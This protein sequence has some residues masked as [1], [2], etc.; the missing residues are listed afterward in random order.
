[1]ATR[2]TEKQEAAACHV[3]ELVYSGRLTKAAGVAKLSAEDRMNESTAAIFIAIYKSLRE[4][5]EFR[6]TTSAAAMRVL[7]RSIE[8]G[9]GPAARDRAVTALR[10]HIKYFEQQYDT[11]MASMRVVLAE[12]ESSRDL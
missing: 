8:S 1:M 9:H 12:L 7:V 3:A 4:G 2:L 6:R 10:A 5:K 11:T